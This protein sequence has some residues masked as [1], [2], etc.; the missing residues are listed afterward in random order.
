MEEKVGFMSDIRKSLGVEVD[1]SQYSPLS[2]AYLGDS[3]YELFI[4]TRLVGMANMQVGKL[5]KKGNELAM[6]V[7]QAA[8]VDKLLE[9]LTEEER[10]YIQ[11]GKNAKVVNVPK[12]CNAREYHKATGFECL[13]GYLYLSGQDDRIAEIITQGWESIGK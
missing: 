2:L 12:S 4:R 8:M 5:N 3:V 13:L 7:T 10:T 11:R 9:S 6:A 1:A